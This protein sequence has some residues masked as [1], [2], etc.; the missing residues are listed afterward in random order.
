MNAIPRRQILNEAF[1]RFQRLPDL[2]IS[3]TGGIRG[4]CRAEQFN[5]KST[6]ETQ[7]RAANDQTRF[8]Q[9]LTG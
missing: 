9:V 4:T 2:P 3:A 6:K 8:T 1:K 5:E 7:S